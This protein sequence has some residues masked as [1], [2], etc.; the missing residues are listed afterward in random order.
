MFQIL[1][2]SIN[3]SLLLHC[4]NFV[5]HSLHPFWKSASIKFMCKIAILNIRIK[6]NI[7]L[8]FAIN[9]ED[10]GNLTNFWILYLFELNTETQY[11]FFTIRH[12]FFQILISELFTSSTFSS[13]LSASFWNK[14]KL[15]VNLLSRASYLTYFKDRKLWKFTELSFHVN[16]FTWRLSSRFSPTFTALLSFLIIENI[17]TNTLCSEMTVTF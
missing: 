14:I 15:L 8:I 13:T 6:E 5:K 17:Q 2:Q 16:F 3:K 9:N 4:S 10:E 12:K 1:H 11:R 7:F